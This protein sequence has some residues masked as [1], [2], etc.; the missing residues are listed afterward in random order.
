MTKR[1]VILALSL[2]AAGA[3][4]AQGSVAPSSAQIAGSS[5]QGQKAWS[6]LTASP[7]VSQREVSITGSVA[8]LPRRVVERATR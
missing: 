2:I 7:A 8:P 4:H 3:A 5:L 1:I 6:F